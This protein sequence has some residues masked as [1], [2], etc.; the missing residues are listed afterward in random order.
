VRGRFLG[1]LGFLIVLLAP[2][3]AAQGTVSLEQVSTFADPVFI[4]SDPADGNRL[5]VVEQAG[6]IIMREGGTSSTFLDLATTGLVSSGGEQGMLSMAFAPDYATSGLLYVY[7]TNANGDI[8]IDEFRSAAGIAPL[9]SRR[10][11]LVIP[12]PNESNHNGGQLQFGPD[13]YLWIGTGDGGGGGDPYENAQNPDSLLGKLLRIDPARSGSAP[14]AIPPGNPWVGLPGADEIA[15]IGLRNP[16]RF[17]FDRQS[18]DLLVAD[19]G[20]ESW[21]EINYAQAPNRGLGANY[22]WDCREGSHDFETTGCS[23]LTLTE[24]VFEYPHTSGCSI[25]GGYVVR[26][27]GLEE[28]A[29]RYV[30]GDLCS[31]ELRSLPPGAPAAG[32]GPLGLSVPSLSSFGE[33][34][35]G[36]IYVTGLRDNVVYRLSDGAPASCGSPVPAPDTTVPRL[37][38]K[39]ASR[40]PFS[41]LRFIAAADEAC[42]LRVLASLRHGRARIK[43]PAIARELGSRASR[44]L[45]ITVP[46]AKRGLARRWIEEAGKT[47]L[48]L[49]ASCTDPA[50]NRSRKLRETADVW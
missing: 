31:G 49:R 7:Y 28:L 39:L 27:P 33:D 44:V 21:E 16:W 11:V 30:Y 4:T 48:V 1:F 46:R 50:N 45:S 5:F 12:H 34:A 38:I 26:D 24:P 9:G 32:D 6:R 22:G 10:Q 29:G 36:R 40:L 25:T 47:K 37:A 20:Q 13:G 43:L 42:S 2:P 15:A 17:S 14:F 3:P 19:V 35:C 41:R 23:G 18:G 8:Q